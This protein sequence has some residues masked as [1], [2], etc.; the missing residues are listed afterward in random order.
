MTAGSAT[1]VAASGN[2][3]YNGDYFSGLLAHV[4]VYTSTL[5]LARIQAHY[6]AGAYA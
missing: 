6:M 2:P 1:G 3:T 4:A 5:S